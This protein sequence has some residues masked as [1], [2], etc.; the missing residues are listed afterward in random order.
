MLRFLSVAKSP[1]CNHP[2]IYPTFFENKTYVQP[3]CDRAIPELCAPWICAHGTNVCRCEP[4]RAN[5]NISSLARQRRLLFCLA[6]HADFGAK[7]APVRCRGPPER[8]PIELNPN[9][10]K[11]R[12]SARKRRNAERLSAFEV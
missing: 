7:V 4:A 3:P 5:P 2:I 12:K 8:Q 11:S 10:Q 1:S 6:I 9:S